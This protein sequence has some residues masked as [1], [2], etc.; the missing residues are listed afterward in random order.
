MQVISHLVYEFKGCPLCNFKH[1]KSLDFLLSRAKRRF[2]ECS[3]FETFSWALAGLFNPTQ[4]TRSLWRNKRQ[5]HRKETH[6][7][8]GV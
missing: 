4:N 5:Y 1:T 7:H 3:T 2:R 6:R 8:N